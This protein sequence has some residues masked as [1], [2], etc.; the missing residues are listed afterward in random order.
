VGRGGEG[1][2]CDEKYSI[3]FSVGLYTKRQ[4]YFINFPPVL[5]FGDAVKTPP[6]KAWTSVY[7]TIYAPLTAGIKERGIGV[8]RREEEER[9]VEEKGEGGERTKERSR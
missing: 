8:M 6:G 2:R 4:A 7:N 3:I 9:L 1:R 5:F